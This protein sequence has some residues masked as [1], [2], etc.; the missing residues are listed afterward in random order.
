MYQ[1]YKL[2]T[3]HAYIYT[4]R[5]NEDYLMERYKFIHVSRTRRI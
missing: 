3:H 2:N 4:Y 5:R 1:D